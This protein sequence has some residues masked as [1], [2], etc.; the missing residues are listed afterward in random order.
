MTNNDVLR[1]L[2]YTLSL[3]DDAAGQLFALGGQLA[4]AEEVDLWT[5]PDDDP[6]RVEMTDYA[7]ATFLNGL[8]V[9]R[10]GQRPDKPLVA[11]REL[12]NNGILRK[13][14]IAFDWRTQDVQALVALAGKSI[15]QAEVTAFFR[16]PGTRQ[17]RVMQ[18]QY[19]R[20]VLTGLQRRLGG[21]GS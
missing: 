10:R 5:R 13:L 4:T 12:T 1:R 18:D 19:L 17:Y 15:G 14:K 21:A 3:S 6:A 7:L 2:R 20:W 9:E 16:R 11:E 8:I